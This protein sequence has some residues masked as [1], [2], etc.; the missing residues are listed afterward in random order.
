MLLLILYCLGLL[1]VVG[2]SFVSGLSS[3]WFVSHQSR[4]CLKWVGCGWAGLTQVLLGCAVAIVTRLWCL[5]SLQTSGILCSLFMALVSVC[6][7]AAF[8]SVVQS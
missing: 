7:P 6:M 5:I 8:S 4:Y 1:Y 3:N 2:H